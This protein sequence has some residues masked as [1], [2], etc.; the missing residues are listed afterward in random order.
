MNGTEQTNNGWLTVQSE[1]STGVTK[2]FKY[3]DLSDVL[4]FSKRCMAIVERQDMLDSV[5]FNLN[6]FEC[7]VSIR[8]KSETSPDDQ[9]LHLA[10]LID[11][12]AI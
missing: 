2:V 6:G 10:A 11:G 3:D 5:M 7:V 8:A 4:A 12:A 9:E 1:A